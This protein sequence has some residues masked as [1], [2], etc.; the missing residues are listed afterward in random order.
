MDV[1]ASWP[2]PELTAHVSLGLP[3]TPCTAATS[4]ELHLGSMISQGQVLYKQKMPNTYDLCLKHITA[5]SPTHVFIQLLASAPPSHSG[6]TTW[7]P[8][9]PRS[10]LVPT[11][12]FRKNNPG[13]K[14]LA[15]P[16]TGAREGMIWWEV[17]QWTSFWERCSLDIHNP[18]S[19]L[20]SFHMNS[21]PLWTFLKL[22]SLLPHRFP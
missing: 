12:H 10:H 3:V 22:V 2:H 14:E 11:A 18:N 4:G 16:A 15:S 5:S 7:A 13:L 8:W 6:P 21:Y 9:E 19:V 1:N 17:T 20:G